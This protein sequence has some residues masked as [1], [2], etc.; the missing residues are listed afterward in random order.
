MASS[1][2][3][4][5]LTAMGDDQNLTPE[6]REKL[7]EQFVAEHGNAEEAYDSS[8]RTLAGAGLGITVSLAVALKELPGS[9]FAA[10]V[11]FLVALLL[12]F[13]SYV[14]VRRDMRARMDALRRRPTYKAAEKSRWT[15][16]TSRMNAAAGL[17][18]LVG[19]ALLLAFIDRSV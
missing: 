8:L 1:C 13:G 15:A 9:G 19:G 10:A 2:G 7:W 3:A 4:R 14:F 12:N 17:A 11:F 6:Q 16:W 5:S 18:L